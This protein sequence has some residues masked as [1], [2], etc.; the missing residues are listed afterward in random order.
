MAKKAEKPVELKKHDEPKN[1]WPLLLVMGYLEN[2]TRKD[3]DS[4]V[5]G[6]ISRIC[7]DPD[8]SGYYLIRHKNGV[9]FEIQE[10]GQQRALLPTLLSGVRR[11]QREFWVTL[12]DGIGQIRFQIH[13][14]GRLRDID[15]VIGKP[16]EL[17]LE[18]N[19]SFTE[20]SSRRLFPYHDYREKWLKASLA[21]F[22]LS[23]MVLC[24]AIFVKFNA[25][26]QSARAFVEAVDAQFQ[27]LPILHFPM[28]EPD[29]YI[30]RVEY[31]N[32]RWNVKTAKPKAEK[33]E[34]AEKTE[35][36]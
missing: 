21:I 27:D 17:G 26:R 3:A 20:P 18:G 19:V 22:G 8:N 14:D 25:H 7:N 5:R 13:E 35:S 9:A 28:P 32:G 33:A 16:D 12:A 1:P 29:T 31:V 10:G 36:S 24:A 30:E 34:K 2:V 23:V 4:Y 6:L 11:G 15:L